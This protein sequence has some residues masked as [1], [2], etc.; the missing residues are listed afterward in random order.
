MHH[1]SEYSWDDLTSRVPVCLHLDGK[2][3]EPMAT[4]VSER[5]V[6]YRYVSGI[7]AMGT[8][9]VRADVVEWF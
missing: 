4:D 6:T 7:R 3:V 1:V 8:R 5:G 9:K 2:P